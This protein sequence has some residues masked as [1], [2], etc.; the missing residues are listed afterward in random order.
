M[1]AMLAKFLLGG[2]ITAI[3]G[4][5]N[6]WQEIKSKAQ[7]DHERLEA[8]KMIEAL[9]TQKEIILKAQ[10]DKY[11]RWVRIGFASPFIIYNFKLVVWDK[12]LGL[13]ATDGLSPE[14]ANIEMVI[15]SGYFVYAVVKRFS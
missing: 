13:G 9:N 1:W 4:E 10:G 6:K 12:V 8:D 5:I 7:N 2:G 14:L 11:E 3:G 15:I